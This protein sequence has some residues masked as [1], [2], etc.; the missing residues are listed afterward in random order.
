MD[1][2]NRLGRGE[3]GV[4]EQGTIQLSVEVNGGL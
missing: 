2:Y 1:I 3:Q 4:R